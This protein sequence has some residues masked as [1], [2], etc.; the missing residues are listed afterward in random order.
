MF[1]HEGWQSLS[2][3]LFS[4]IRESQDFKWCNNMNDP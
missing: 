4:S 2:K 1:F 3:E